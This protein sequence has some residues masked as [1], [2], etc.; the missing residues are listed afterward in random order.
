MTRAHSP[1]VVLKFGGTSVSTLPNWKNIASIVKKRSATG[2]P[3]LVVHSAVTKVTD[4]LEKLLEAA[5]QQKH[6]DALAV[7]EKRHRDLA[8]ELGIGVSPSSRSISPSC[9]RSP[10]ASRWW[11]R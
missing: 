5:L 2:A 8:T 7:I 6:E 1:W 4:M 11:V 9:V 10:P 3:V